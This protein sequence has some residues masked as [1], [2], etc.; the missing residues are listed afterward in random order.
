MEECLET[1]A[2]FWSAYPKRLGGNP[3]APAQKKFMRLCAEGID[4]ES[5]IA[6]ARAYA[7]EQSKNIDTPYIAMA[8]TWLNQRRWE[9]YAPQPTVRNVAVERV[10]IQVETPQWRAWD[11][12]RRRNEG[13]GWPQTDSRQCGRLVRGWWF[14]MEWPPAA[15]A[16]E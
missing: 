11:E 15:E 4:P 7:D 8:S 14:I 9:D 10:F 13:R 5:I 2:R 6:G 1:F 16:A 12:W 3:K